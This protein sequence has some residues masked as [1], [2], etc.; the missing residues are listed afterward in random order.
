MK[1]NRANQT[2]FL[3]IR[4]FIFAVILVTAVSLS[5]GNSPEDIKLDK[6]I[7]D[8]F[9]AKCHEPKGKGDG[10]AAGQLKTI[11]SDLTKISSKNEGTFPME[12]FIATVIGNEEVKAHGSDMP[13]CGDV[14]SQSDITDEGI[15]SLAHYI[16]SIQVADGNSKLF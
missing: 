14:F 6:S 2:F 10:K 11:P 9:C 7:Y 5:T 8:K 15:Q 4:V 1:G 12:E 16:W 13:I 3:T